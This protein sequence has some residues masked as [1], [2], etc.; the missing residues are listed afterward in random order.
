[1]YE[2]YRMLGKER[3]ADIEREAQRLHRAALARTARSHEKAPAEAWRRTVPGVV[4]SLLDAFGR[5]K[6][7]PE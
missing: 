5:P 6:L 7:G 4:R 2:T 1:M 3:E